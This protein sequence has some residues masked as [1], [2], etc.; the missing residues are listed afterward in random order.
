MQKAKTSRYATVAIPIK[1]WEE[2]KRVVEVSGAY[3]GEAEFV[4]EA[5]REK[6]QQVSI[7]EVADLE[8]EQ[9]RQAI[10]D[11]IRKHE[12]T[13]PSDIA[14]DTGVPYFTV[15]EMI[16]RLVDEGVIEA[17]EGRA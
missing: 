5:V 15:T 11:Y 14:A 13:Y 8:E 6:L 2:I 4:R 12:R 16:K 10:V 3:S 9:L 17:A 7:V 1:L